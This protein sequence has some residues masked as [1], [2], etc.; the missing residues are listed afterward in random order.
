MYTNCHALLR[1]RTHTHT[2]TRTSLNMRS[3][4]ELSIKYRLSKDEKEKSCR[5]ALKLSEPLLDTSFLSA[6]DEE[7]RQSHDHHQGP[8][9]LFVHVFACACAPTQVADRVPHDQVVLDN[10]VAV[11]PS[12]VYEW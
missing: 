1:L 9:S 8:A 2:L 3:V 10:Q 11:G 4:L 5:S 12:R 6:A 7:Q